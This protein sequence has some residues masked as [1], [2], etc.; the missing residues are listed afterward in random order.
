MLLG[1]ALQ[2]DGEEEDNG[3]RDFRIG[4][5]LEPWPTSMCV[6][7]EIRSPTSH[8]IKSSLVRQESPEARL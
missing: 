6:L 8:K 1:E 7:G 3:S 5:P 4:M 2:A